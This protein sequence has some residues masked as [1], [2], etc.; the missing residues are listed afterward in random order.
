MPSYILSKSELWKIFNCTETQDL[1]LAIKIYYGKN[2]IYQE[3]Q[4][5]RILVKYYLSSQGPNLLHHSPCKIH[6]KCQKSSHRVCDPSFL[7]FFIHIFLVFQVP[8]K[9]KGRLWGLR[10]FLRIGNRLKMIKNVFY[11]ML[12]ALFVLEIFVLT[13]WLYRKTSW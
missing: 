13:F 9:I 6:C 7:R 5:A 10:Q 8:L 11:F 12:K 1:A 4:A 3:V 2:L